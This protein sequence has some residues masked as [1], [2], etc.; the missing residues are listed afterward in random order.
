MCEI[1]AHFISLLSIMRLR[2][3]LLNGGRLLDVVNFTMLCF[4]RLFRFQIFQFRVFSRRPILY[5][6][7]CR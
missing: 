5:F 3:L 1:F 6:R 7:A 2:T 4:S